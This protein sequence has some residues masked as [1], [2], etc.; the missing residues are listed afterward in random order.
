MPAPDPADAPRTRR[1]DKLE[2]DPA[3]RRTILAA[4]STTLRE[5]G[6]QGFGIAAVLERAGLST[7]AF[8]RHFGSKDELVAAVF[9]ESA[10]VERRRLHRRMAG[11]ADEIEAVAAW[12]DARLDL[13]FDENTKSDLR[14]LS[15][16][17]Q[18]Q[19]LASPGLVQ[20]AYAEMLKPLSEALERGLRR[21][22]FHHIHPAVDA[23]FIH[24]V[25]WAAVDRQWQT[26]D[27]DRAAVRDRAVSFCLRGLGVTSDAA[28]Q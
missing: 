19:T 5:N 28:T 15:L 9:L 20:P 3:V 17:A 21:G 4:A 2:P 26:G 22:V 27:S 16:E 6:V 13:A 10:R 24:G 18:S 8:Y 25:V 14:R 1:R 23:E 12:I 11:A 7:R